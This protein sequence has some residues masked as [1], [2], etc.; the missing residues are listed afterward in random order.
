MSVTIEGKQDTMPFRNV[1]VNRFSRLERIW[2]DPRYERE[3]KYARIK[4]EHNGDIPCIV[5]LP[6][7]YSP[8]NWLGF[9]TTLD[10][11]TFLPPPIFIEIGTLPC[12]GITAWINGPS[13]PTFPD[14]YWKGMF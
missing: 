2:G 11:G 5:D 3:V 13:D 14:S 6:L 8:K 4:V 9:C 12:P 10:M 7:N 1:T